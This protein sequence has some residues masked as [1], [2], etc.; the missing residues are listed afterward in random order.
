MHRR[1]HFEWKLR[2]RS[3]ALDTATRVMG[4]LNV[5]PDSFSDGGLLR[6][7]DDAVDTALAMFADGAAIVDV[8]GESTRPGASGAISTQQE[9]DRVVPVIEGIRRALPDALLSID[10]YRAAT[11]Q[12][13]IAAG[14]E[15]VNDVS[16][17]LWDDAM[18][19][20]CADLPCGLILMHARGRP[21]DWKSLPRL[22][23]DEVL[24]LVKR[25]LA[26]RLSVAIA[27][28]IAANSI[29]LDPGFGFGKMQD[30]NY[31][32]LRGLPELA[33]L[34]QPLL[35]GVSRKSFLGH[36]L[37]PLYGVANAPVSA[38]EHATLAAS[39]IAIL[40]GA[41]LVRVH[42][43]RPAVEAALIADA[44]IAADAAL[45]GDATLSAGQ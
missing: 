25:E 44:A 7:V 4:I 22:A 15:I 43:V 30:A 28:G 36:T 8:G 20:T 1:A 42:Q 5:T 34:G 19:A 32:L 3:L 41:S 16:G 14:A 45:A 37:A 11:A 38:R 9:I 33:A 13:A 39:T 27:A 18:A 31:A 40:M 35:A 17:L 29:I 26:E 12:A 21:S 6:S 24:P 10:T 2:T 23:P